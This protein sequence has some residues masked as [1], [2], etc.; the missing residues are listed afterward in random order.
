MGKKGE[1]SWRQCEQEEG[2][3]WEYVRNERYTD[4]LFKA[5]NSTAAQRPFH[6]TLIGEGVGWM[7]STVRTRYPTLHPCF[8]HQQIQ[9]CAVSGRLIGVEWKSH[10]T[11]GKSLI[12]GITGCVQGSNI[13]RKLQHIRVQK[14]AFFPCKCNICIMLERE[15]SECSFTTEA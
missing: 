4:E 9:R 10:L 8:I 3:M 15:A 13:S 12:C 11:P 6:C 1:R 14:G 5:W 2:E 7:K